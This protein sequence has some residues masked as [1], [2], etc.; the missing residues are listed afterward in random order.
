MV[1]SLYGVWG[2]AP[3]AW[4][5]GLGGIIVRWNG[6]T[7]MTVTSSFITDELESIWGNGANDVWAVGDSATIL[8]WNGS[9]WT[10]ANK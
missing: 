1:F 5:V 7:W 4:A 6:T 8:R 3:R 9:T 10:N 2:T